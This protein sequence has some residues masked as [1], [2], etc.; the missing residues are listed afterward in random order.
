[1][2]SKL[3]MISW[4]DRSSWVVFSAHFFIV[5]F[6]FIIVPLS[7]WFGLP[8]LVWGYLRVVTRWIPIWLQWF[9][10]VLLSAHLAVLAGW[11]W[12]VS[13]ALLATTVA[14]IYWDAGDHFA[15]FQRSI[16]FSVA[17]VW[18]LV[19]WLNAG[20]NFCWEGNIF[21]VLI[22]VVWKIYRQEK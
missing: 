11:W 3:S 19:A 10:V 1:M 21:L 20:Q 15:W 16:D 13:L 8:L 6:A 12:G 14:S 5:L 4:Q 22:L 9:L 17:A 2:Q 18:L 7:T